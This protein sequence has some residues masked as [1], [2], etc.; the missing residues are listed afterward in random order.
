[1]QY[2]AILL[3]A[4]LWTACQGPEGP[5]GPASSPKT[6]AEQAA[7]TTGCEVVIN[8][9]GENIVYEGDNPDTMTVTVYDTV[10]VDTSGGNDIGDQ[11]AFLRFSLWTWEKS[12]GEWTIESDRISESTAKAIYYQRNSVSVDDMS[13]YNW[14]EF[15]AWADLFTPPLQTEPSYEVSAGEIVISD[16]DDVI[17]SGTIGIVLGS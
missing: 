8:I 1:M 7:D 12:G 3:A 4:F 14:M 17:L 16:P 6:A 10:A 13:G 5:M 9:T 11:F 2:S 15:D